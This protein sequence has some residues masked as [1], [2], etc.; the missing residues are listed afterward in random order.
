MSPK[1]NALRSASASIPECLRAVG[2]SLNLLVVGS[3]PTRPPS[4]T[5][6]YRAHGQRITAA[7]L[8]IPLAPAKA[9]R[10]IT[11]YTD[12]AV[13]GRRPQPL[14]SRSGAARI[15]KRLTAAGG[16]KRPT[17]SNPERI[18]IRKAGEFGCLQGTDSFGRVEPD[19]FIELTWQFR[20]KVVAL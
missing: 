20:L 15:I 1:I 7:D 13:I 16:R 2:A 18:G 10:R 3:I 4:T 5:G 19:V 11:E 14:V 8:M 9:Q 12:R 17:S 6:P